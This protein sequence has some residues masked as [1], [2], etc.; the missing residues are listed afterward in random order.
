MYCGVVRTV[1]VHETT[2]G[3]FSSNSS[4]K[5][6]I[7]IIIYVY[8]LITTARIHMPARA[9]HDAFARTTYGKYRRGSMNGMKNRHHQRATRKRAR[10][11]LRTM[12]TRVSNALYQR[13]NACMHY[14]VYMRQK[15]K[16]AVLCMICV[17][18]ATDGL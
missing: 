17:R 2:G 8:V 1:S 10:A 12:Y 5:P 14:A 4:S 15:H 11:R 7:I 18:H 13:T 16:H 3:K 6:N 9:A